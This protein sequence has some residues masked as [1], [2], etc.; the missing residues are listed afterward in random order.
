MSALAHRTLV[1]AQALGAALQDPS[2]RLVDAR[3]VLSDPAAARAAWALSHLPGAVHADLGRDL[4]DHRRSGLGR[5]SVTRMRVLGGGGASEREGGGDNE[6]ADHDG[7]V[8][9]G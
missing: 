4:S 1:S 2:L 9:F 7:V 5:H 3:A 8:S 6:S